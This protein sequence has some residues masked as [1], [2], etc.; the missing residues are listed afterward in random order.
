MALSME[1]ATLCSP[2]VGSA[3]MSAPTSR[4]RV[5]LVVGGRSSEH[6]ISCVSGRA[7]LD[8]IDRDR[9]EV[10]VVGI[11]RDGGWR[12][13]DPA[14]ASLRTADG[15]L[16][17]IDASLPP[18]WLAPNGDGGARLMSDGADDLRIDVV[19]PLLHGPWGED[20][21]VQGLFETFGVRY[22]G[23]G[24]LAS[25]VTM[26]KIAM[27]QA[28]VAHGIPVVPYEAVHDGEWR[29][30]QARVL[31]RIEFALDLPVFVKPARAGS[32]MGI[33]RVDDWSDLAA[34]ID[35]AREHDPRVLVEQGVTGREIEC[36]VLGAG[37]DDRARASVLGEIVVT[38][39]RAFYDFD[40]KYLAADSAV[41]LIVP[42]VLDPSTTAHLQDLAV[43]AFEAL[44][45][46][47]LARVDYFVADDGT[48]WVNELNTMPG[49]TPTSMYPRMWQAT[50]VEYAALIDRLLELALA[51]P[52]GLR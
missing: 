21:T 40:A 7:V 51:R 9:W 10:E 47:G 48:A 13:L 34:A 29:L 43:R 11:D 45:C 1:A 37:V 15:V 44:G 28:L 46:E 36:G 14:G 26:D 24:V 52:T 3:A 32:S 16:P 23:S 20:G 6:S 38:D 33:S 5:L 49:F 39:G 2:A 12:R 42:A 22:V 25:A 19:L 35:T 18:C 31:A 50:G 30:G 4:P 17:E 41:D 27:K 8:V